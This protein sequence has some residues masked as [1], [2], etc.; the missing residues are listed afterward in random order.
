MRRTF[1]WLGCAAL[2]CCTAMEFSGCNSTKSL[3][4]GLK[5]PGRRDR[6]SAVVKQDTKPGAE[7]TTDLLAQARAYEKAG[8]FPKA[9]RTY[10]EYLDGDGKPVEA[11]R[12]TSTQ[13]VAKAKQKSNPQ[14]SDGQSET[15][16]E[17]GSDVGSLLAA[18]AKKRRPEESE[19]EE[20]LSAQVPGTAEDPWANDSV[21]S[22]S[23]K[24]QKKIAIDSDSTEESPEAP[25]MAL[26]SSESTESSSGIS[27]EALEDL[28]DLD[29]G[30]IDWGD[31]SKSSE[32]ATAASEVG[33]NST[34][35]GEAEASESP[36]VDIDAL[37]EA[38][39]MGSPIVESEIPDQDWQSP[40]TSES[41][42]EEAAFTEAGQSELAHRDE[43]APPIA[44]GEHPSEF[45][46]AEAELGDSMESARQT[47]IDQ[48]STLALQCKDC[49]PW[50][51][52]QVMKLE[53]PHAEV[54][55]EGLNHLAEMGQTARPAGTAVRKALQDT[56][57]L[58]QAHAAWALWQ[59]GNDPWDSIG[60]LTSLL[61]NSNADVVELACY[62]LGDIGAPAD[63]AVDGL[64]LLRDHAEGTMK[65][66][67]AE[68]L[69]R[70]RG[71]DEKS[72]LVLTT[73]LKSK[74]GEE[75]WIAAVALG[76]CRGDQSGESVGALTA[77]LKDHDPEVRSAAALS[78]GGLG[79]DAAAAK[80]E[81]QRIASSDNS[82]VREAALAALACL[83]L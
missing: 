50:I 6:S 25:E 71:L 62:M 31:E 48:G 53:S 40:T 63:S 13:T 80:P 28:L 32:T 74:D 20:A 36:L 29:D 21:A 47:K 76:R 4:S 59:I 41:P 51:Y 78:L 18:K 75:R 66:Q 46:D 9:A 58:V 7:D 72:L 57:P 17:T 8:D 27:P 43:F 33:P 38:D 45:P 56:N 39:A 77:A 35:P 81:L 54:R 23:S 1:R 55:K 15:S 3:V 44:S 5:L 12:R 61:D 24:S 49:E 65:V 42:V 52:A 67:A 26:A 37:A 2:L 10:R 69:I 79:R 73:A 83:K 60:T 16:D 70:I 14:N 34:E 68:A 64:V 82:Q 19:T 30:K 22:S 11:D